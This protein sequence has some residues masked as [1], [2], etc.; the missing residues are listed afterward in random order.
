MAKRPCS[1]IYATLS[2][3]GFKLVLLLVRTDGPD[4]IGFEFILGKLDGEC[5]KLV[6]EFLDGSLENRYFIVR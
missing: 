6:A 5:S 1:I 2:I 4:T 3:Q